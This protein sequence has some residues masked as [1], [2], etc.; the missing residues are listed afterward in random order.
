M[1]DNKGAVEDFNQSI[2]LNPEN[3]DSYRRRGIVRYELKDKKG[4]LA[5]LQ[6]AAKLYQAQND[7]K[8]YQRTL[9]IIKKIQN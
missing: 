5:D 9:E 1:R 3:P 4:A 2:K 6:Q 8:R 7:S